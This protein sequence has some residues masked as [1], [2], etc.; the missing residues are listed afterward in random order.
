MLSINS[1]KLPSIHVDSLLLCSC[2]VSSHSEYFTI[3]YV[4]LMSH[5]GGKTP[6][7]DHRVGLGLGFWF[8]K[9]KT[10]EHGI[11]NSSPEVKVSWWQYQFYFIKNILDIVAAQL[12]W[13]R[14]LMLTEMIFR[15]RQRK[16]PAM[17]S[18]L[19]FFRNADLEVCLEVAFTSFQAIFNT[20]NPGWT[21]TF[22][23]AR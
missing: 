7:S 4:S 9:K 11:S 6:I 14:V 22:K 13:F 2:Q 19:A 10:I 5:V 17:I 16:Y 15:V 3:I 23:K 1:I 8:W 12:T 20:L 18:T 21:F